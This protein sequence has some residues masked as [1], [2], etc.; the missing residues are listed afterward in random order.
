MQVVNSTFTFSLGVPMELD[1]LARTLWDVEYNSLKFPSMVMRL[2][3]PRCTALISLSGK[4]VLVGCKSH[5]DA[6]SAAKLICQRTRR[7]TPTVQVSQLTCRNLVGSTT[8]S[9]DLRPYWNREGTKTFHNPSVFPGLHVSLAGKAKA[10]VFASGI[11]FITG[12][13]SLDRLEEAHL[14]LCFVLI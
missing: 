5:K 4:V 14:E 2:R 7:V 12:V 6:S 8:H 13:D 11:L 1:V 9:F 10:T 3:R